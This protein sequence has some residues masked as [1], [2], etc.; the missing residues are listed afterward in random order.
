M[1]GRRRLK[2]ICD[3]APS[4]R[5]RAA[6]QRGRSQA[7]AMQHLAD[8]WSHDLSLVEVDKMDSILKEYEVSPL[9][10]ADA[11]QMAA[12]EFRAG[13]PRNN[14]GEKRSHP[15]CRAIQD[16]KCLLVALSRHANELRK[17]PGYWIGRHRC[18]PRVTRMIR[19]G[20]QPRRSGRVS[21]GPLVALILQPQRKERKGFSIGWLM[22]TTRLAKE[23]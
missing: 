12:G 17:E 6:A 11:A 18:T 22:G 14:Q 8:L 10:L 21:T 2:L 19:S 13:L 16:G 15:D 9:R 7:R 5:Q 20:H 4:R 1:R 3:A 23:W